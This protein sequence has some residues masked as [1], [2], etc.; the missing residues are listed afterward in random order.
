MSSVFSAPK[1]IQPVEEKVEPVIID[2]SEKT[3]ELE[4][5]R[6]KRRGAA[7]N[8]IAGNT[9]LSGN[10]VSKKTLGE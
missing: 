8:F 3:Q 10:Q 6:K 9:A 1:Q 5:A 4:K 7:T 2:N